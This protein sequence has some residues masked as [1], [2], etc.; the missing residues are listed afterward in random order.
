MNSGTNKIETY[1]KIKNKQ[2][3]LKSRSKSYSIEDA[4]KDLKK[5]D[6]WD[7]EQVNY[8]YY[9]E[10]QRKQQKAKDPEPPVKPPREKGPLEDLFNQLPKEIKDILNNSNRV[11]ELKDAKYQN[12]AGYLFL[13][14]DGNVEIETRKTLAEQLSVVLAA[15]EQVQKRVAKNRLN[16]LLKEHNIDI[17][18]YQQ[19]YQT[20]QEQ[21]AA[22]LLQQKKLQEQEDPGNK[23]YP[24]KNNQKEPPKP[25]ANDNTDFTDMLNKRRAAIHDDASDS[26]TEDDASDSD[27]D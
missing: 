4:I 11:D 9:N 18:T 20:E 19:K 22:E 14:K 3:I 21:K 12:A 15:A 2:E 6:K 10:T 5:D 24:A 17:A 23:R 7:N 26:D 8:K 1:Q 25:Q 13:F 27:F 16:E